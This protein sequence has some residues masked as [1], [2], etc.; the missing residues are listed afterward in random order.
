MLSSV[1]INRT[2][3]I[4]VQQRM[5][6]YW[7][8]R[9]T[10]LIGNSKMQPSVETCPEPR[11]QTGVPTN[12]SPACVTWHWYACSEVN[13]P[14][15]SWVSRPKYLENTTVSWEV[16]NMSNESWRRLNCFTINFGWPICSYNDQTSMGSTLRHMELVHEK[17]IIHHFNHV[18]S[19]WPVHTAKSTTTGVVLHCNAMRLPL[20]LL[21]TAGYHF[22][23]SFE[24]LFPSHL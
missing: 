7:T 11:C 20:S 2:Q 16:N 4:S 18:Y 9:K 6:E 10:G 21:S 3:P 5:W 17:F 24:V 14:T 22:S 15:E 13:L 8:I 12:P 1:N 23:S 19:Q